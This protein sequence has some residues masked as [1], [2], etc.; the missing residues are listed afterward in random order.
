MFLQV[1]HYIQAIQDHQGAPADLHRLTQVSVSNNI[2]SILFG[3]RFQYDD[4]QFGRYL[5]ATEENGKY[6]GGKVK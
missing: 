2:A 4:P 3:H 5:T 1:Q 6:I